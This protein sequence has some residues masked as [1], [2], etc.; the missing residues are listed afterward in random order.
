MRQVIAAHRPLWFWSGISQPASTHSSSTLAS[1]RVI[2][3]GRPSLGGGPAGDALI[4]TEV[5]PHRIF[6]RNGDDIHA[7][8]PMLRLKGKGA[9]HVLTAAGG[10]EFVTLKV[11]LPEKPDPELE[12]FVAHWRGA[13]SPRQALEA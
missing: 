1:N 6:T 9:F 4:E 3:I 8:L 10:D 5:R 11:M 12:K 7:D 2:C 13:Y